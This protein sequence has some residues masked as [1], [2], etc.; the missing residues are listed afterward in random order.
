MSNGGMANS[1]TSRRG[2]GL[3]RTIA[4]M[5]AGAAAESY[6][7]LQGATLIASPAPAFKKRNGGLQ[8][9]LVLLVRCVAA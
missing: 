4:G 1:F 7:P 8:Q 3:A 5:L 6:S 2:K 9:S